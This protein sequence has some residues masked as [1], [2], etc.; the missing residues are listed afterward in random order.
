MRKIVLFLLAALLLLMLP[1]ACL[2][3]DGNLLKNGGFENIDEFGDPDQW[4]ENTY[5]DEPGYSR[6][7]ITAEKAHSGQYSAYVE[8][9]SLNDARY[10]TSVSVKPN[11][12]Y[13]LSGYV[14]V[15]TMGAE[16][17]GANFGLED[18]ASTSA[19]LY[20]TNGEWE[21]LEWYGKTGPKQKELTFGVRVGGF[22][23]ESVGVAYFDDISLEKVKEVPDDVV[24]NLWYKV[25]SGKPAESKTD[26][27][28]KFTGLF[29]IV[30]LAY[31]GA[32]VVAARKLRARKMPLVWPAFGLLLAL[33][34][35]VRLFLMVK[36]PGYEVDINC[37]TAWSLRMASEGPVH[38]YA[39]GY[40]C[41]YPPGYMLLLWPVGQLIK[42]MGAFSST[43]AR[44]LLAV[45][46]VPVLCDLGAIALLFC[47][48]RKH[49]GDLPALLVGLIYALSP[50]V[51][52][53][54]A[55]W[56]QADAVLTLLM[57]ICCIFALKREWRI[58]LPLYV[59]AVLVK[60]QALLFGPVLLIWLIFQLVRKETRH[61][62]DIPRLL[63]GIGL[64]L[65]AA[66]LVV[67]PFAVGKDEPLGWIIGLYGGTLSSY[68]YATLNTANLY[69]LISANWK[70]L[71]VQPSVL[72][73][74]LTGL[75]ALD[76]AVALFFTRKNNKELHVSHRTMQLLVLLTGFALF[77]FVLT[78]VGCTYALYGYGMMALVYLF[79]L[80]CLLHD[81]DKNRLPFYLSLLLMGLYLLAVKIHE[82]YLFP[83]L[84]LLLLSFVLTKDKRMLRL[85]AGFSATTF[86]NTA[87]VL[88]N[89]IRFG[90][91]QGH[92][93]KDTMVLN[94]LLC[95]A[96]LLLLAYGVYI[97]L[98]KGQPADLTQKQ[99][100]DAKPFT[101]PDSYRKMLL[102]PGDARL[103][104]DRKDWA[105]ML[106]VT[107]V[108][109]VLAFTNLGSTVA[110][111]HG[112]ISTSPTETVV[113]ELEEDKDFHFMYYCGV[114]KFPFSISVS[115]D[116]DNWSEP[117]PCRMDQGMCY[118]WN[119]ALQSYRDEQGNVNYSDNSR[120]GWLTLNGK[121]L[122]LHADNSGLN[123]FE[124]IFRDLDGQII[125]A[126]IIAHTNAQPHLIDN[127]V[128]PDALLDEQNTL[129]GEPGWFTGT[130]FDEIYHARTAY[131]HLH[132]QSPYETTHPPLGKLLMALAVSIFGMTPFGWRFAGALVGVL[133]L[134]ALYLL[135]KQLFHRRE[136]AVVAMSAFA[137]DLMHYTQTRIATIDS[138]PVF[139]IL[140]S[141]LF[142]VRYMQTDVFAL[143]SGENP[144]IFTKAFLKSLI[145]LLLSGIAMG[146]S[147]ASKWIGMYSAVGLAVLFFASIIRQYRASDMAFG[148][149]DTLE[150]P[151]SEAEHLRLENAREH[152]FRRILI[153]CGFCVVFFI[154]IPAVIYYLS[155]IPYL[156]PTGKVS[157][158]RV[159][160]AQVGMFNYHATP[161]L[162]M[163]H[164]YYS[165]WYEWPFIKKPMF[166]GQDKFE[167]AGYASTIMCM[168]NPWVYYIGAAAMVAVLVCWACKYLRLQKGQLDFRQGDGNLT[169]F[170]IVIGFAAQYLPWV[171]VPRGTYMYHYFAS[172]PFII[173]A[174]AWAISLIPREKKWLM[175]AVIGVYL[176]GA[177]V[178]FV[179]FF[180][181]ASG[182]LTSTKWLDAMKW[183]PRI[184]Y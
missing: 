34:L 63:V 82:R 164:P 84:A 113:F 123:M 120:N 4:Y 10:V 9:A 176:L 129:A 86:V 148:L 110:P 149:P 174:T 43:D 101:V 46:L 51:L 77:Q 2:A 53:T 150:T 6:L 25:D 58:A 16:G 139:F 14:L 137:L 177:A 62:K 76:C 116:G 29:V 144:R 60:P 40:F 156:A 146:L 42:A 73:P 158:G 88:E 7:Q 85:F 35:F 161:R 103:H 178:F 71:T 167:P 15:E 143:E 170:V 68:P 181:Y 52:V 8:N 173:L 36:V 18:I 99:A 107:A 50:A 38:F 100:E 89:S 169:L 11:S 22:S 1:V 49:L 140:L 57:L 138:F 152:T 104:M 23:A 127:Y 102:N 136:M 19:C 78:G 109:A 108:Y 111:Q 67:L 27:P 93:N 30:A 125:P 131:E 126:K 72:L 20:D 28:K 31:V 80:I 133:M 54:G 98:Q 65:L 115:D 70:P 179:M 12:Y 45:K 39:D 48:A 114:S 96:N 105:I 3:A 69:Y 13:R 92:L 154:L 151:L 183:F 182:W 121:Y 75:I 47:L 147:I 87:I 175:W 91:S 145:P 55:A 59:L 153:T 33:A 132:G 141:Y 180:P 41:D 118:R 168:G 66:V 130:Y 172:V 5:H 90:A 106:G 184:Y 128:A 117:Y 56:G 124:V 163:D 21:Y 95:V 142:M 135:A 74:L 160:D 166:Y 171:L 61:E 24:P 159:I 44:V 162:G 32:V 79:V 155:Y 64:S 112:W 94:M 119:Y 83:G 134:P 97:A 157:I 122:R 26:T 165:P 37:F 17:N 81:P